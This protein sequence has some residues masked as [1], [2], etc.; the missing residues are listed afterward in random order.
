MTTID[1]KLLDDRMAAHLP[2]Y[3]TP[4]SAG[5]DLRACLPG[6][7]TLH[8]GET[9][10]VPSGLAIHL[11]DP[12]LAA[13]VLPLL[14]SFAKSILNTR[15]QFVVPAV[16]DGRDARPVEL[17]DVRHL[18]VALAQVLTIHV[19]TA[20]TFGKVQAAMAGLP[21]TVRILPQTGQ[22]RQA[23]GYALEQGKPGLWSGI[24]GGNVDREWWRTFIRKQHAQGIKVVIP[25]VMAIEKN[26]ALIRI[27]KAAEELHQGGLARAIFA[28]KRQNFSR[29]QRE[30]QISHRPALCTGI[31]ETHA[32]EHK[33]LADW[34]W[35][36]PRILR[37]QN[38][39]LDFEKREQ[40]VEIKRLAGRGRKTC[41]KP[42]KQVA[43]TAEGSGE[44]SEIAN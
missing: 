34:F 39:R 20:D 11:A 16:A 14:A 38:F 21:C 3:A 41:K 7:I 25:Q 42:F 31:P 36:G 43:Q 22:G 35:E 44:K 4:G 26:A 18:G 33:S 12:G 6:P 23:L 13:M 30:V 5:L 9:T 27:V 8:P 17:P 29:L 37:R 28:D 40:V 32:L 15:R 10:L 19:I 2:A 1:V 24:G